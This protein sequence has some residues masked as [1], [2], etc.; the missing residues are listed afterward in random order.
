[1]LVNCQLARLLLQV[2]LAF[3]LFALLMGAPSI[4]I[5]G[6]TS[7]GKQV[8]MR[9]AGKISPFPVSHRSRTENIPTFALETH[10]QPP[11]AVL[12]TD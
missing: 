3:N 7:D 1:M 12:K 11:K 4:F 10:T 2:W 6:P 5:C 8:K 9:G